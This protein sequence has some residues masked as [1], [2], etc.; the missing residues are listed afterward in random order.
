MSA[1]NPLTFTPIYTYLF[2][3]TLR[4]RKVLYQR[5]RPYRLPYQ[6]LVL[7]VGAARSGTTALTRVFERDLRTTV[8]SEGHRAIT[9]D[10]D[11]IKR[12][13]KP[14]PELKRVVSQTPTSLVIMKPLAGMPQLPMLLSGFERAKCIWLYREYKDVVHSN[15]AKWGMTN[16]IRNLRRF[17]ENSAGIWQPGMV[18]EEI[19]QTAL[20]RFAPDMNPYDAA[21]LVWLLRNGLVFG[22]GLDTNPKVRPCRYERFIQT[23]V[24]EAQRL[25][26]FLGCSFPGAHIV[27]EIHAATCGKGAGIELS[28]DVELLC[29]EMLQKLDQ[30]PR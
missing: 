26:A 27:A 9:D 10:S 4:L 28:A 14:L 5:V 23:P 25:Y 7:I 29:R 18:P 11:N 22:L 17:V 12:R 3:R 2:N 13:L 20:L 6:T 15:L 21:A 19:R 24:E 16:G 1:S 30:L 8:F